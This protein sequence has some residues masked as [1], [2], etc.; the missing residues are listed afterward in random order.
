MIGDQI[1]LLPDS[2]FLE[3]ERASELYVDEVLDGS[4]RIQYLDSSVSVSG[5]RRDESAHVWDDEVIEDQHRRFH[6]GV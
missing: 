2:D 5:L 4:G 1:P 6:H 3:S